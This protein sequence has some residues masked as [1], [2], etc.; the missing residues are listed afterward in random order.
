VNEIK[1]ILPCSFVASAVSGGHANTKFHSVAR[2]PEAENTVL[3]G[4]I[5]IGV[6]ISVAAHEPRLICHD[7]LSCEIGNTEYLP[8]IWTQ[9]NW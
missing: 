9:P 8:A 5:S 2:L 6:A 3:E 4:E 1:A 7:W